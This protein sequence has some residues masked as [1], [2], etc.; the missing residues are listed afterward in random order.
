[1]RLRTHLIEPLHLLA[2]EADN[3]LPHTL[4]PIASQLSVLPP[5]LTNSKRPSSAMHPLG[6]VKR[7]E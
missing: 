1:V 4:Q 3:H 2:E 7:L 5:S 6:A